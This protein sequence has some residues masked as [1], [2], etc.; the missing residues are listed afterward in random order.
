MGMLI[1]IFSQRFIL[2]GLTASLIIGGVC[3]YLGVFLILKRI[4]FVGAAVSQLAALGIVAGHLIGHLLEINLEQLSFLFAI[5][6]VFI[7][8]IPISGGSITRES[9][10]GYVYIFASALSVIIIAWDPLAEAEHLDLF[11]GNILFINNFDLILICAVSGSVFITHMV[12]FKEFIFV[13]FDFNTAQTL[14][15]PARLYDFLI[16]LTIGVAISVGIR[17]AGILF[18]F[19]SL[20]IPPMIGLSLF[21]RLK[22]VFLASVISIWV[23][24]VIGIVISYRYDL[25]T[26]PAISVTNALILLF[27]FIA[28]RFVLNKTV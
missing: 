3:A 24:S 21:Q 1:E 7:F 6:G 11:S 23:S 22:W 19:S 10:I 20:I 9:L 13:S 14:K 16:Y 8:W 2:S 4:V 26:G 12:F 25:P 18:I 28:K 15:I 5:S 17:S 27:S